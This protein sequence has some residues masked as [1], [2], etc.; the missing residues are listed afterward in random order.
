[1]EVYLGEEKS[2]V[3]KLKSEM[4]DELNSYL[5]DLKE[6]KELYLHTSEELISVKQEIDEKQTELRL[7][8]SELNKYKNKLK[9]IN[10]SIHDVDDKLHDVKE[11]LYRHSN[12]INMN[13]EKE[14]DPELNEIR[15][16]FEENGAYL[17][18][19]ELFETFGGTT[20]SRL[21]EEGKLIKKGKDL[22]LATE[23]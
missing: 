2:P 10:E 8:Q 7:K 21:L 15:E 9:L 13:D 22:A 23:R 18:Y 11:E 20:I 19:M 16:Y 6:L 5:D 4:T 3:Q 14:S 1:M 17:P 12:N